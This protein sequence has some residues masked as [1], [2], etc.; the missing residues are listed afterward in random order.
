MWNTGIPEVER[1]I[2]TQILAFMQRYVADRE[3]LRHPTIRQ[4]GWVTLTGYLAPVDLEHELRDEMSAAGIRSTQ[5]PH[6]RL[7]LSTDDPIESAWAANTWRNV[8][9]IR[10]TSI[11]HAAKELRDRQRNWAMYAPLHGGRGP[12]LRLELQRL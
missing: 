11:G 3:P 1:F 10:V 7:V 4:D 5:R 6:G 12:D 8:E 9:Q 2:A